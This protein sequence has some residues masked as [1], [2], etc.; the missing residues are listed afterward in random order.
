M[1]TDIKQKFFSA[2]KTV[3]SAMALLLRYFAQGV[4]KPEQSAPLEELQTPEQIR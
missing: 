4:C 2:C 1:N 3:I